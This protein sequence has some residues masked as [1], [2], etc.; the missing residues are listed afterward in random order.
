ML[1]IHY[2]KPQLDLQFND[3]ITRHRV[4]LFI[5]RQKPHFC[6]T[7]QYRKENSFIVNLKERSLQSANSVNFCRGA[8]KTLLLGEKLGVRHPSEL[9]QEKR[10]KTFQNVLLW[11]LF[12][13]K[14]R[15]LRCCRH[16]GTAGTVALCIRGLRSCQPSQKNFV[17]HPRWKLSL[18]AGL[19]ISVVSAEPLPWRMFISVLS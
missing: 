13:R 11:L 3:S 8:L 9:V 4:A 12:R 6:F 2:W 16:E 15:K 19:G 17:R 14:E 5:F 18:G 1:F 7:K 10:C